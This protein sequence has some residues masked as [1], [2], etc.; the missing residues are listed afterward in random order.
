MK[1]DG[2]PPLWHFPHFAR[3]NKLQQPLVVPEVHI[4]ILFVNCLFFFLVQQV[5][6]SSTCFF[7][8]AMVKTGNHWFSTETHWSMARVSC[9]PSHLKG[10]MVANEGGLR[11]LETT[12][13]TMTMT[14]TCRSKPS[15]R[16]PAKSSICDNVQIIPSSI[17]P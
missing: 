1:L 10:P 16:P 14:R 9:P 12:T 13:P 6:L 7:V 17:S 4:R 11:P 2:R 3:K 8:A 5:S 15:P